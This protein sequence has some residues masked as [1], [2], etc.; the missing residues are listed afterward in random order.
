MGNRYHRAES[1]RTGGNDNETQLDGS[2]GIRGLRY[3]RSVV[4]SGEME[5][6]RPTIPENGGQG[7]ACFIPD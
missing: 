1:I 4:Q 2:R 3:V 7:G 5:R 6:N